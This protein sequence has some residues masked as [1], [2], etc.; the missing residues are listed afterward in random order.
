MVSSVYM[1]QIHFAVV[2]SRGCILAR[3]GPVASAENTRMLPPTSEGIMAMVKN[4]IPNPPIHCVSERQNF[5]AWGSRST[6]SMTLAPVV[7]N[8]DI[9]SKYASV[10]CGRYPVI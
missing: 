7:E 6:L 4:T 5:K 10:K 2:F 3:I 8:P 9:V 1:L